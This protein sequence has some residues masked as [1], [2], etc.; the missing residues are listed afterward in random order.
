VAAS[1]LAGRDE[2]VAFD[3]YAGVARRRFRTEYRDTVGPWLSL[4]CLTPGTAREAAASTAWSV[5]AV[6]RGN[7]AGYF[8]VLDREPGVH[9]RP[10]N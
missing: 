2:L 3:R 10:Q 4:V 8:L 9:G 6:L 1:H 5:T 7:G